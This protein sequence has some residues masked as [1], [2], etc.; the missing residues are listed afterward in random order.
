MGRVKAVE[1]PTGGKTAVSARKVAHVERVLPPLKYFG[2]EFVL[3]TQTGMFYR[4]TPSAMAL[5]KAMGKGADSEALVGVIQ[6][7]CGVDRVTA[8]RDFELLVNEL[9]VRGILATQTAH[10]RP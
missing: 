4:L 8:V 2:S 6:K 10:S 7:H 9:A 5:L 1:R 3:D